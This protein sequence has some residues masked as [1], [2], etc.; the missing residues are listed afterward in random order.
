MPLTSGFDWVDIATG[1]GADNLYSAQPHRFGFM[2]RVALAVHDGSATPAIIGTLLDGWIGAAETGERECYHS[3]MAVLYRVLA[4]TWTF[5]ILAGLPSAAGGP[6]HEALFRILLILRADI[7][8]LRGEIGHAYP[9][10]H[11]LADGFAGWYCGLLFPEFPGADALRGNGEEILARELQRQFYGDGACFEHST[12]YQELGC[13]MGAAY[14]LLSR[15]NGV[16][17]PRGIV[18]RVKRM[19]GCHA[20]LAGPECAPLPV[21]DAVE[22]PFFPLEAGHGW[23]AGGMRE[24]YRAL[25]DA[26][27]AAAPGDD[28]TVERAYWLLGGTL[29]P[30]ARSRDGALPEAFEQGGFY[31]LADRE[32]RSRLVF[33]SGPE[34]AV[35]LFAG[36]SHAD[37]LGVYLTVGGIPLIVDAGTYTYRFKS[38]RWPAQAP[39]WRAYLAGPEAHNGLMPGADPYGEMKRD[40]RH[41]EV[42]CR[43]EARRRVAEPRLTWHEF[44]V[45][46]ENAARGHRRG[47]VHVHGG[48]WL[49]YDLVPDALRSKG[50][51]IGLQFAPGA[52]VERG[53]DGTLSAAAGP[54]RCRIALSAGLEAPRVLVGS[55]DPLAGWVSPRYG[56]LVPAPQLRAR[57]GVRGAPCGF[58][59][60]VESDASCVIDDAAARGNSLAFRV[61]DGA[62]T[63][64]LVVR[65]TDD[66]LPLAAW[67]AVSTGAIAWLRTRD[68]EVVECRSPAPGAVRYRGTPVN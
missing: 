19:L 46:G 61:K 23:A 36:H 16:E 33:R 26:D 4:L 28:V 35:E 47:V 6:P 18:E 43:V 30:P 15:R 31:V 55:M 34:A 25:F 10:N 22:D 40:F 24:L 11:L 54:A 39:N 13:E 12:H 57:I 67:D 50:V 9:N 7:E 41:R 68:G 17:L 27:I 60:Q 56:E 38:A 45:T 64:L 51:S 65:T 37:V 20:A 58:V 32:R 3:A 5:V 62:F 53:E 59:L 21:G 42:P 52:R 44:E 49:V 1:P 66:D 48:Y 29:A 14:V 2:P 63:D 8:Y